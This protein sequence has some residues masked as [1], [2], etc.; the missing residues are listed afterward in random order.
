MLHSLHAQIASLVTPALAQRL[1]LLFNHVLA[2]EPVATERLRPHSGR[3][4]C[5]VLENWPS[6]LPAPPPLAWR[7]TPAGLLEWSGAAG[8]PGAET[9]AESSAPAADMPLADLTVR[10][11][12]GNPA[13]VLARAVLGRLSEPAA[14]V[15]VEG[16]AQ[17]AGDVNWLLQNLRWDVA[18][19]VERLFGPALAQP[20]QQLGRAIAT[21]MRSAVSGAQNIGER[22]RTWRA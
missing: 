13:A 16:D 8:V 20:L 6:L 15:Q 18:A 1:T 2:S 3:R 4:L 7:I 22:L 10:L 5:L 12:A 9:G 19:D 11:D 14:A 17:L 21:G